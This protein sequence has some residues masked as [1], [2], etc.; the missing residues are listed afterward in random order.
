MRSIGAIVPRGV[1]R[2]NVVRVKR[3]LRIL[4]D[5]AVDEVAD[6]DVARYVVAQQP[7][8][9]LTI[10]S[11]LSEGRPLQLRGRRSLRNDQQRTVVLA[12]FLDDAEVA[13]LL[14]VLVRQDNVDFVALER[15]F[16]VVVVDADGEL[17]ASRD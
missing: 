1:D 15:G 5:K 4:E 17:A 6:D 7:A 11:R 14:G 3:A 16:V 13:V 8:Q 9:S 2:F 10:A 12:A